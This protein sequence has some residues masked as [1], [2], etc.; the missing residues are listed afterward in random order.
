MIS[1]YFR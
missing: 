1:V